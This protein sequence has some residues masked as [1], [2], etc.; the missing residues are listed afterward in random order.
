MPPSI[1]S[2]DAVRTTTG[3]FCRKLGYKDDVS[4]CE[5]SQ[6][7]TFRPQHKKFRNG[8]VVERK[9]ETMELDTF[10]PTPRNQTAIGEHL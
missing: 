7:L 2:G 4:L 6:A 1:R 3:D 5:Q 10:K 9:A 8:N